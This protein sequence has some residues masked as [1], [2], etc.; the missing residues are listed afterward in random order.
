MMGD[1]PS[2]A[3]PRSPFR[4]HSSSF[5]ACRRAVRGSHSNFTLA[6]GLLP[7]EQRRGMEALY[8]WMR[9]TDDIADGPGDDSSKRAALA[10]WRRVTFDATL[11]T[12]T[13]PIL[14]ALRATVEHFRIPSRH[15]NDVLDGVESD[16]NPR[17]IKTFPELELYCRRVAVAV[18][19]ACLCIWGVRSA[20]ADECAH[21]AGMAFQLT[22]ILRDLGEDLRGGRVYLPA[23]E[24]A[25][26]DCPPERWSGDPAAFERLMRFQTER[27]RVYYRQAR[28][29]LPMLPRPARTVYGT[30]HGIYEALLETI[31]RRPHAVLTRRLRVPMAAKLCILA[32]AA[33]V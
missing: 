7:R 16:L 19:L 9:R 10:D 31:A 25:K 1:T 28:G 21:A 6:F 32:R 4:E 22:N 18:G 2:N 8:A 12:A 11:G 30:M 23:E 17:R 20:A 14:P 33:I 24:L 3:G 27:A 13:E 5:A 29:L 15:F 26:F